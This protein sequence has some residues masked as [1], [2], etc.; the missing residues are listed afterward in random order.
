MGVLPAGMSGPLEQMSFL[1]TLHGSS[2]E[3]AEKQS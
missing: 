3:G 2:K 1:S